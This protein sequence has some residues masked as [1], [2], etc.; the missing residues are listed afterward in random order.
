MKNKS[1]LDYKGTITV[2]LQKKGREVFSKTY[3]N[4]AYNDLFKFLSFCLSG[5]YAVAETLRPKCIKLFSLGDVGDDIPEEITASDTNATS[6]GWFSYK[7]TPKTET[8]NINNKINTVFSFRVPLAQVAMNKDTN[9]I[10]LYASTTYANPLAYFVIEDSSKLSELFDRTAITNQN[11][12]NLFI[13]WTM[14][15]DNKE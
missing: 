14:N 5:R 11:D 9:L 1:N 15:I 12:Y 6:V 4:N 7:E 3:H 8:D 2:S 13:K 10:V